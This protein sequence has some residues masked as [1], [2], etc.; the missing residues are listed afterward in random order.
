[1]SGI[2][3]VKSASIRQPHWHRDLDVKRPTLSCDSRR[4]VRSQSAVYRLFAQVDFRREMR[5]I[6]FVDPGAFPVTN[7]AR[8]PRRRLRDNRCES[9]L[10]NRLLFTITYD[11]LI[12]SSRAASQKSPRPVLQ[13]IRKLGLCAH[14]HARCDSEPSKCLK[15]RAE[16]DV[17][18]P[19]MTPNEEG[20]GGVPRREGKTQRLAIQFSTDGSESPYQAGSKQ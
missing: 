19:T 4:V 8:S 20:R 16:F 18:R 3:T 17:L 5:P 13:N 7:P 12:I 2:C 1:M 9:G 6:A 11:L 15:G 10:A 14:R